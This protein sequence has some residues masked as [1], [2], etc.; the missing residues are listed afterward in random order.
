MRFTS[1]WDRSRRRLSPDEAEAVLERHF[2]PGFVEAHILLGSY[3]VWWWRLDGETPAL[4]DDADAESSLSFEDAIREL[5]RKRPDLVREPLDDPQGLLQ[6][7]CGVDQSAV[8]A[9]ARA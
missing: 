1:G 9:G 5:A 6:S 8:D 3:V 4:A 2:A 7:L